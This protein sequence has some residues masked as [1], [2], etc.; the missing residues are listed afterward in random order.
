M[1]PYYQ[2]S[3]NKKN[4]VQDYFVRMIWKLTKIESVSEYLVEES[5]RERRQKRRLVL[6]YQAGLD[7]S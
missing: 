7:S 1:F 2:P 3:R 6:D 4:G 5:C